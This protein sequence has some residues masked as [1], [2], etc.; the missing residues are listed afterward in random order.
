[1]K[2][3]DVEKGIL[4]WPNLAGS[5]LAPTTAKYGA[6]KKALADASEVILVGRAQWDVMVMVTGEQE[7]VDVLVYLFGVF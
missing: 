7:C 4:L 3:D 2:E 6:V 1:M 5:L